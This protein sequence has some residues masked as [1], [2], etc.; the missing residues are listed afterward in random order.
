MKVKNARLAEQ[1]Q[2]VNKSV[3]VCVCAHVLNNKR[4][5]THT[6]THT[7]IADDKYTL[8]Q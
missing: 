7:R 1:L 5:H 3:S 4:I 2:R 8:Y 6:H